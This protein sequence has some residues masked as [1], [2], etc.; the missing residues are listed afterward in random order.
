MSPRAA[1]RLESLGFTD[2][3]DFV[4]GKLEW[5]GHGLPMEGAGPHYAVA[6]EVADREAVLACPLGA[7]V[8][9]AARELESVA[10]DYC[11]VLN[12]HDIVLGRLRR[13]NVSG[14]AD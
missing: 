2:V 5:I 6:G 1:W 13:R 10:H 9:D 4:D 7:S 3:N 14:A 8:G 12:D 11:V